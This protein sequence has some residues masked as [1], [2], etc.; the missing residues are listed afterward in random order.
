MLR[1]WCLAVFRFLLAVSL[2]VGAWSWERKLSGDTDFL[3]DGSLVALVSLGFNLQ[4]AYGLE[5]RR[6]R[7]AAAAGRLRPGG[8]QRQ[9]QNASYALMYLGLAQVI[10][11]L[12]MGRPLGVRDGVGLR[13]LLL[14]LPPMFV[15]LLDLV[16]ASRSR[17][18]P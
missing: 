2:F 14:V 9:T 7:N 4:A 8:A 18:R 1:Q 5:Q 3:F 15:V 11:I 6:V 10:L 17:R 16:I 12:L 13:V